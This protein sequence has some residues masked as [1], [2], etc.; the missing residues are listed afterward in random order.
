[1]RK[2]IKSL[3]QIVNLEPDRVEKEDENTRIL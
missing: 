3:S 1:M 2:K